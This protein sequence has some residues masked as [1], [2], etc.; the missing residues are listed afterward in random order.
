VF[1]WLNTN[2]LSSEYTPACGSSFRGIQFGTNI[3]AVALL[4]KN[5]IITDDALHI[6]NVL[7]TTA[8]AAVALLHKNRIITD[9]ALHIN[10]VLQTTTST[11]AAVLNKKQAGSYGWGVTFCGGNNSS[12]VG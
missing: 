1:L 7:Q 5:R 9:D 4:H 6:N 2:F 12:I 11:A 3:A 10:N 8:S